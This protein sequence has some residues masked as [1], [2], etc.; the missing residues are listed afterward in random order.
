ML[1]LLF[2]YLHRYIFFL[3]GDILLSLA[4]ITEYI[5]FTSKC[6]VLTN[7]VKSVSQKRVFKDVC[8]CHSIT[9]KRIGGAR[10]PP[11]NPSFGIMMTKI[12]RDHVQSSMSKKK[13]LTYPG[14]GSRRPVPLRRGV[15]GKRE[16][17]FL[18]Y[19]H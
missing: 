2:L 5:V 12:F 16:V 1:T 8:H 17:N 11:A 18:F 14:G 4:S 15:S 7:R 9:K 19:R 3:S 10:G 13:Y 6:I